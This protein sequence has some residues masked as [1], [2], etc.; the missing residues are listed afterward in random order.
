MRSMLM[1]LA[2]AL[3]TA[4]LACEVAAADTVETDFEGFDARYRQ[5]PG[6]LEERCRLG[7]CPLRRTGMTRRLSLNS[8]APAAFGQQSLRMSNLYANGE[9]FYQ[10]YS[11]PVSSTSRRGLRPIRSTSASSRS[12]PRSPTYQPELFLSVSPDPGDGSR[13][14][15]VALADT[16]AGIHVFVSYTPDDG[17]QVRALQRCS[18]QTVRCHIRSASGSRSTL[19]LTTIAWKSPSTVIQLPV[20]RFPLVGASRR[21]RTITA[22]LRSR[23]RR[24]TS[25][26]RRASTACSSAPA[27]P[28]LRASPRPVAT[29]STM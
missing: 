20:Q 29:C 8:G 14:S 19:A 28:G 15:W 1:A 16:P 21:G 25:I 17:W 18:A 22:P 23:H 4:L 12:S 5:R 26:R 6:W 9:Y 3:S 7:M 13:M 27:C 10:T 11:K 24:R 2:A